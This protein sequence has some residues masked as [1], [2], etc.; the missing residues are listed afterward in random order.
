MKPPAA[1]GRRPALP[2][3]Y[4]AEGSV[5]R[6]VGGRVHGRGRRYVRPAHPAIADTLIGGTPR[7]GGSGGVR[8][9]GGQ[10]GR[11]GPARVRQRATA[12][13]EIEE[14]YSGCGW[15]TARSPTSRGQRYGFVHRRPR[16]IHP[17]E[18]AACGCAAV[19][20]AVAAAAAA[21]SRILARIGD[22]RRTGVQEVGSR[23]WTTAA[24]D[25]RVLLPGY[26]RAHP[27]IRRG[28]QMVV[29]ARRALGDRAGRVDPGPRG[30]LH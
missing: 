6:H 12:A 4:N 11:T 13:G 17:E 20:A 19:A 30:L 9:A 21:T 7:L 26:Y 18:D 10:R 22:A 15:V 5:F 8:Q 29:L 23:R 2:P 24:G 1:S 28:G 25:F 16:S 27:G 14:Y 3:L